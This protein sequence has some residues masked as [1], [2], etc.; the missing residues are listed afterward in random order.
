MIRGCGYRVSLSDLPYNNTK[1][2]IMAAVK[3]RAVKKVASKSSRGPA[4]KATAKKTVA[5]K[6]TTKATPVK[7]TAKTATPKKSTSGRNLPRELNEYGFVVGSNSEKIV[8]AMLD[9]GESRQ[10]IADG[11][12]KTLKSS[13][14]QPVNSNALIAGLLHRLLPQ[15]YTIESQWRLVPP[16]PQSKAKATRAAKKKVARKK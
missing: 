5:K 13:N 2:Y 6:S 1:E 4:K 3:K 10:S 9:G 8:Q 11:L 15:G 7:K 16:T 14:G 12:K